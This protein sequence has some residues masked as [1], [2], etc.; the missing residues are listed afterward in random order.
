[1]AQAGRALV[2][3]ENQTALHRIIDTLAAAISAGMTAAEFVDLDL[4]YA[5]AVSPLW[6]AFQLAA[7]AAIA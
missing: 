1:M 6:D 4:A 7:R 5:P 3:D 2:L